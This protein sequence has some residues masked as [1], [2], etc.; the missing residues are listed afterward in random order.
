M[1][2]RRFIGLILA[3]FLI[4]ELAAAK[5]E[6][7][8]FSNAAGQ[9]ITVRPVGVFGNEVRIEFKDGREMNVGPDLFQEKDA[10][11]LRNWAIAYL[12][13]NDRLLEVRVSRKEDKVKDFKQDVP[14]TGGGVATGALE[15]EEYKG[16]YEITLEN[17]SQFVLDSI[18]VEYRIFS[19]Q[20]N[21]AATDRDDV[22]Y[23]RLS[24]SMKYA[25]QPREELTQKT[26]AVD[27][28]ETKLGKGIVW[29]GGG[30]LKSKAKMIGVWFRVYN[31]E[32]IV[33]EFALPSSITK[34]EAW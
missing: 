34:R 1:C 11:Y 9:T 19:E 23:L 32:T 6:F 21:R 31:G 8:E 20:E 30:D 22:K 28:V 17:R 13:S 4:P 2:V 16:Y 27:M 33:H 12:G 7:R 15:I 10:L 29:S 25:I 3:A 14:L 26:N 24:G 5:E 18:H